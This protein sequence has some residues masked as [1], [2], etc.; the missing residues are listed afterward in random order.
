MPHTPVTVETLRSQA[1]LGGD[2]L[3]EFILGDATLSRADKVARAT[4][5]LRL[6]RLDMRDD[7]VEARKA[8]IAATRVVL[9][10]SLED[11]R[12]EIGAAQPDAKAAL[13]KEL[14]DVGRAKD[15]VLADEREL[16]TTPELVMA[17]GREVFNDVK[18]GGAREWIT[19]GA[20]F[21]GAGIAAHWVWDRTFGAL[22]RWFRG[23]EGKP[24]FFG[25]L[26]KWLAVTGAAVGG[27]VGLRALMR[28]SASP[29]LK[30]GGDMLQ[31][32]LN[33]AGETGK[34]VIDVA[35]K[36]VALLAKI[37]EAVARD[38][39]E[40]L[41]IALEE[42]LPLIVENGVVAVSIMGKAVTLPG[43]SFAKTIEWIRT[44]KQPEDYWI[45]WTEAGVAYVLGKAAFNLFINGKLP[46]L[47]RRGLVTTAMRVVA[48]PLEAGYDAAVT[49]GRMMT[50]DGRTVLR[51][52]ANQTIPGRVAAWLAKPSLGTEDDVR[53]AVDDWKT[54]QKDAD[55][56]ATYGAKEGDVFSPKEV[57]EARSYVGK[58]LKQIKKALAAM[59]ANDADSAPMKRLKAAA[60]TVGDA[61]FVKEVDSFVM[62][63]MTADAAPRRGRRM[64][65][66]VPPV[67]APAPD[68]PA[69]PS[70][71]AVA[72]VQPSAGP[73]R[74]QPAP[75]QPGPGPQRVQPAPVQPNSS[76]SADVP[77]DDTELTL[78]PPVARP[79]VELL[80]TNVDPNEDLTLEPP[81]EDLRLAPANEE[82]KL[83]P[84]DPAPAPV[85]A[86]GSDGGSASDTL[87]FRPKPDA[88]DAG[89]AAATDTAP[90]TPA[91]GAA[92]VEA[93]VPSSSPK[94]RFQ[95][96]DVDGDLARATGK[97]PKPK[98][99]IGS[100]DGDSL[101]S[102]ESDARKA[103][104]D[105]R[106]GVDSDPHGN[107]DSSADVDPKADVQ[108]KPRFRR[109]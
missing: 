35:K 88:G 69:S 38:P 58:R 20:A 25:S 16:A 87:P 71:D 24:G 23:K 21:A 92:R 12:A 17:E 98:K 48:G 75:V 54:Y 28:T 11:I 81:S 107:V 1:A 106:T 49:A 101:G 19:Y 2:S 33:Q 61:D 29:A 56:M 44:G 73:V 86:V 95:I 97:R 14:G 13:E 109:K 5:A 94:P 64:R 45:V 76:P 47:S 32:A 40:A 68:A 74:V 55:F 9:Q 26:F 41:G 108:T 70:A 3:K 62:T 93:P 15:G 46:D 89:S 84:L 77:A 103:G 30:A 59:E 10:D 37:T 51:I 57:A 42:G 80:P 4:E 90:R 43:L 67:P 53:A 7:P 78:E 91:P 79:P 60:K 66:A 104:I 100:E 50:A 65:V 63:E 31:G 96:P 8:V 52:Q 6:L 27:A 105:L 34:Q 83:A 22:G 102:V 36:D 85:P 39:Q 72:P 18:N 99:D 82:L